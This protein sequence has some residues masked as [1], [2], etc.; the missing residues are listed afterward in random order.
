MLAD[1]GIN[2][3]TMTL[4]ETQQYGVLRILV[5]DWERAKDV[6]EKNGVLVRVAEV[7]ALAVGHH[8]GGLANILAPIDD[9]GL[10]I[11]YMYGFSQRKNFGGENADGAVIVFRFDN[12]DIAVEALQ[13]Q[14][15]RV[16]GS[17]ELFG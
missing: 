12:P 4:A 15:V 5:K 14:N 3:E 2:V 9:A 6:C 16:I 7:V 13:K 1:N 17:E 11:E 8:P 10:N